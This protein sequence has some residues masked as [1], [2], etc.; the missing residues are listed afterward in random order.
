MDTV[1]TMTIRARRVELHAGR[2]RVVTTLTA[3]DKRSRPGDDIRNGPAADYRSPNIMCGWCQQRVAVRPAT[4]KPRCRRCRDRAQQVAAAERIYQHKRQD[5][6]LTRKQLKVVI[7]GR[8]ARREL[9]RLNPARP[10]RKVRKHCRTC[11][12]ELLPTGKCGSC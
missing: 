6:P 12:L 4:G 10:K 1:V 7:A 5:R 9:A 2:P 3:S 11:F 8:E